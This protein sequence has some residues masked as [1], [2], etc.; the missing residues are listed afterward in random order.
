MMEWQPI[1]SAPRDGTSILILADGMAI[2][3]WYAQGEWSD[4]TPISPAEYSG[5]AWV[6]FDDALQFEIEEGAGPDGQDCHG[7]VTHWMPL[8][9]PPKEQP[10]D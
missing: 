8:P 9:P 7:T 6:A 10:H 2:E 4:D 3:A 5:P 1:E